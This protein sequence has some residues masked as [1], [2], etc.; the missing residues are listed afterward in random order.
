M[1][2]AQRLWAASTEGRWQ[3]MGKRSE[4]EQ[5]RRARDQL[6]ERHAAEARALAAF[7][8]VADRRATLESEL[9]DLEHSEATAVADMVAV[10]DA[11]TVACL[12]GWSVN[13]VRSATKLIRDGDLDEVDDAA[14]TAAD[15]AS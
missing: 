1:S 8:E 3:Q 4:S 9:A 13:R 2:G 7:F 11:A 6:R 10:A 15:G 5:Q 12:V 14:D